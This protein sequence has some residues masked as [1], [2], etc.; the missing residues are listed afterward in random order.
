MNPRISPARSYSLDDLDGP[1]AELIRQ[2]HA[3]DGPVVLTRDG[4]PLAV[5]LS[6]NA[7]D[8]LEADADRARLQ[9]AVDEA[10]EQVTTGET[11]PHDEVVAELDRWIS[12][13]G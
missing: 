10:E 11:V 5:L 8:A 1:T 2:A 4:V 7:F 13:E 6:A 9:R 12:D 3:E